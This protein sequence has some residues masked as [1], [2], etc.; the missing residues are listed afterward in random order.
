MEIK[1]DGFGKA[2]G[3]VDQVNVY[4]RRQGTVP[5][6]FLAPGTE[7]P[8]IDATPLARAGTP[9]IREYRI[10]AV[11]DDEKIGEYSVSKQITVT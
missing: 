10:R 6:S 7:S 11:I 2:K 5:W 8:Y 1:C 3:N 9:E 4:S